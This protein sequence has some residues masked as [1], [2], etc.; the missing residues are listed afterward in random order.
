MLSDHVQLVS[1][2]DVSEQSQEQ[3]HCC[4]LMTRS[5]ITKQRWATL[6]D[7]NRKSSAKWLGPEFCFNKQHEYKSRTKQYLKEWVKR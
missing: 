3:F 7:R 6:A 1:A 2:S 5:V 4:E